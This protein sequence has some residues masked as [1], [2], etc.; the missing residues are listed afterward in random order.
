MT[1]IFRIGDEDNFIPFL[2]YRALASN[3]AF[4]PVLTMLPPIT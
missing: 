1:T 2:S 4:Q 3:E